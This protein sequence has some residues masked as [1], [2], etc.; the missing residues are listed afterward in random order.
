MVLVGLEALALVAVGV[1]ELG[2]LSGDRL[3]MGITTAVFFGIYGVG[4]GVCAA[5]LVRLRSWARAPVVLAQLIQ[6]PVAWSFRGGATTWGAVT[7]AVAA[8][9]VLAGVFHPASIRALD[10]A[11]RTDR[12][13][14]SGGQTDQAGQTPG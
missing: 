9:I 8:L 11:D 5:R 14:R 3:T 4:L 6:L 10:A 1:S 7:L 13:D 2:V 12:S